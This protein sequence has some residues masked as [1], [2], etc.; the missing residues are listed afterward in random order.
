MRSARVAG[1]G[2]GAAGVGER[3][4]RR[5]V[6]AAPSTALTATAGPCTT[7]GSDT[8]TGKLAEP[9]RLSV[10]SVTVTVGGVVSFFTIGVALRAQRTWSKQRTSCPACRPPSSRPRPKRN[11]I[12]STKEPRLNDCEAPSTENWLLGGITF[13]EAKPGPAAEGMPLA[14]TVTVVKSLRLLPRGQGELGGHGSR[15]GRHA[16]AA[17]VERP[18]VIDVAAR[19]RE[20]DDRV[21]AGRLVVV[22]VVAP[23]EMPFSCVPVSV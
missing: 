22:A 7:A 12:G 3:R 21:V 4:H 11:P 20:L 23:S 16:G 6:K 2:L 14:I 10:V 19:V 18:R 13:G 5:P 8:A 17:P 1:V 15:A 9:E